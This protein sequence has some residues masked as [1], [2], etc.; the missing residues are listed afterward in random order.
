VLLSGIVAMQV[1][2]LKLGTSIGRSI[3]RGTALQSRNELLRASVAS[4]SDDQRIE[5]LAAGMG[6]VMA[7]PGGVTFLPAGA[8]GNVQQAIA[9]IHPPS[10][11]AFLAATATAT[12]TAATTAAT[13]TAATSA[14]SSSPPPSAQGLMTGG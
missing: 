7:T 5:G 10:A 11:Q 6:M 1:E 14:T 9:G 8:G 4:L 2:E 3:E 12:T 13:T